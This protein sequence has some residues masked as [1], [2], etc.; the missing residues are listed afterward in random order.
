MDSATQKLIGMKDLG[1]NESDVSAV[2][3]G[4]TPDFSFY[5]IL[6]ANVFLQNP[7]SIFLQEAPDNTFLCQSDCGRKLPAPCRSRELSFSNRTDWLV[8]DW[9]CRLGCGLWSDWNTLVAAWLNPHRRELD[10][11]QFKVQTNLAKPWR[12]S[13]HCGVW[14]PYFLQ[15][16]TVPDVKTFFA[17]KIFNFYF[18]AIE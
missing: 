7:Q 16:G 15:Q 13:R 6:L 10:P 14:H 11:W 9:V 5:D 4:F 1:I 2:I 12:G 18:F 17:L 8:D 3:I